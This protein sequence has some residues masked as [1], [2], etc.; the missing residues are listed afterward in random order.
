MPLLEID[1]LRIAFATRRGPLVAVDDLSIS[2][3]PGEVLGMVGESGAGKSLTAMA[4]IGLLE[5][6][7][8][9]AG[10]RIRIE[11]RR[12]DNLP[13]RQLRRLRGKVIGAIFQ[14]PLTSL[15]P[16]YTVAR[17]MVETIQTHTGL[18][19]A[20]ARKRAIALL[21]EVG[22]PSPMQRIDAYPHQLSGGMRQRVVIALALC[23]HPRLI[24]A[25]EPTSALDV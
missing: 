24:I 4:I 19:A 22:M 18:G 6:P 15:D 21:A 8:Q 23:G 20:A 5:P 25:D 13:E 7:A 11:G 17:Q 12:I 9:I 3:D 2:I 16:L 14:D 10:G 1:A